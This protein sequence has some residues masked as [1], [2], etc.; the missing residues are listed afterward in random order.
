MKRKKISALLLSMVTL[1]CTSG[2]VPVSAA[3]L[4]TSAGGMIN[5]IAD[6]STGISNAD[7]GVAEIVKY[8]ADNQKIYLVNG[9]VRSVDIVSIGNINSSELTKLTCDTR[10]DVIA[11]GAKES[12]SA[13]DITSVDVNTKLDII[14]IAVQAEN[15]DENGSLVIL[16]YD[17]NYITHFN[18]G[19]QPDMV[20]FSPD[21]NYLLSADEGEPREGYTGEGAVDPKGSVTVVDLS[22]GLEKA[23]VKNLDFTAF[24][25]KRDALVADQVLL[26]KDILPSVDLEPEYIAISENGQYAY[27]TLQ[28]ANAI[29]T[30]D[31]RQNQI[32]SVQGLG[33]KDHNLTSNALDVISDKKAELETQNLYGTYMPDGIATYN[34]DGRQYI[35]TANEGDSREWGEEPDAYVNEIAGTVT[36]DSTDYEIVVIDASTIDGLDPEKQY[37]FGGR[38]FSI[39]NA[40]TLEQVY[41]SGNDFETITAKLYPDYFNSSNDKVKLDSRSPKKGPEPENVAVLSAGDSTYAFIGLERIG[42]VMM[43]D[44]SDPANAIYTDYI[45]LRS[46][47]G[48]SIEDSGALAPEG[49]CVIQALD[50]PT[51]MPLLL[52]ANEVSGNVS[53][54]EILIDTTSA[55]TEDTDNPKDI[56]TI[57]ET[58]NSSAMEN[59][60][61]ATEA[62]E[63]ATEAPDT[64]DS[65]QMFIFTCSGMLIAA[66]IAL[67]KNNNNRA[68]F[69]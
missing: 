15:Y 60:S 49:L 35:I 8:N 38:S 58:E 23:T 9:A 66:L 51:G 27:V 32:L 61:T 46:F 24:D 5:Q 69:I 41:D 22:Q 63:A 36:G 33:F 19:V 7:G 6:Y 52:V 45:N 11:L 2:S 21:G 53:V 59:T 48:S 43:Y 56:L 55:V 4:Q 18:A 50:S 29:A 1:L 67:K 47:D 44:I 57:D 31:L 26:K 54:L 68:R 37:L 64:G 30:I 62:Q 20:I 12:F 39:W 42:G 34:I 13:G 25:A 3:D 17:G 28:E 40:A 14:A 10:L 65:S 16:D